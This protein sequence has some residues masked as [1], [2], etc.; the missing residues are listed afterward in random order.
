[1]NI[2]FFNH[3]KK[4]CG[5]YQYGYKMYNILKKSQKNNYFY[6]EI[7]NFNEYES[8]KYGFP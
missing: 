3:S 7:D 5:V 1:M 2:I 8:V 6:E 4:N